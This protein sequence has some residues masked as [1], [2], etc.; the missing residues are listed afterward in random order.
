MTW[1]SLGLRLT[2]VGLPPPLSESLR[3]RWERSGFETALE[4]RLCGGPC[5]Q[6]YGA[7]RAVEVSGT[8]TLAYVAEREL[9]L[10]EGLYLRLSGLQAELRLAENVRR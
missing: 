10:G 4:V 6:P 1:L 5:P 7:P 9:W 8:S 3:S 2:E